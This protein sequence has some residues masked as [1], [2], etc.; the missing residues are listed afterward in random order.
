VAAGK[1]PQTN[2]AQDIG[3]RARI[4]LTAR[5]PQSSKGV[6]WRLISLEGTD[7]FGLDF[8]VHTV[9][10]QQVTDTFRL[11]LKGTESPQTDAANTHLAIQFET[12]TLRLYARIPEPVLIVVCDLTAAL[13]PVDCPLYYVWVHEELQRIE[14]EHLPSN[15]EKATVHVPKANRLT[16]TT[17]FGPHLQHH[18]E[19]LAA[20]RALDVGVAQA[21]PTLG[22]R[23][24]ME[25]IQN[26]EKGLMD[27]SQSLLDALAEPADGLWV[28]P[29]RDSMPWHLREAQ[30]ALRH[31]KVDRAGTELE[32][33]A[34]LLEAASP[35]EAA[36]YWSLRGKTWA[37]LGEHEKALGSFHQAKTL[38]PTPKHLSA[39]AEAE[40]RVR[41]TAGYGTDM[42]EVVDE[43]QGDNPELKSARARMLAAQGR[44]DEAVAVLDTFTGEEAL[45]ARAIVYMMQDKP[46]LVLAECEEGLALPPRA[47][48]PLRTLFLLLRARA[49]F[50]LATG[51]A[52]AGYSGQYVP[53]S[54]VP[55]VDVSMLKKAWGEI[56]E[57][58][59]VMNDTGWP[60][61]G[62]FV[63][64]I[65]A[66]TA[67]ML[68]KQRE[69]LPAVIAAAKARPH[70]A[71]LQSA[72]ESMAAQIG[73]YAM[74][75]EANARLPDSDIKHLRRIIFLH[76]LGRHRD[77]VLYAES[78]L[79]QLDRRHEH[80]GP[81]LTLAT[82]SAHKLLRTE[83]VT[84][85]FD[86]LGS[87]PALAPDQAVLEYLLAKADV[88]P[89]SVALGFGVRGL[90]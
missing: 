32:A 27:R 7:D 9:I 23:E 48:D 54:G 82:L 12:S 74:A 69:T 46:E 81:A 20:G 45:A 26:V 76:Q 78:H 86:V 70:I 55:G 38:N 71:S 85:W 68:G 15:Q 3:E 22:E 80:F 79:H 31:G 24:R 56:L 61:N 65:W 44:F 39:W 50:M 83:L 42:Q 77:C 29:A 52:V 17:D 40:L 25:L 4:C 13:D 62:E 35:A 14:L 73:D 34:A 2:N 90:I 41:R 47:K 5:R 6:F 51:E 19:V 28:D 58:V 63:A 53:P 64:D 87:D 89:F 67:S 57:V 59:E 21:R 1:L 49:R 72:A 88:P 75:L 33:A 36:V 16:S 8:Q 60:S 18:L 84:A 66:S 30:E 37:I 43:L 11:Q 10:H